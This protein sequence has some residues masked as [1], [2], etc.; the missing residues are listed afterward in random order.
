MKLFERSYSTLWCSVSDILFFVTPPPAFTGICGNAIHYNCD[1]VCGS[2]EACMCNKGWNEAFGEKLSNFRL[3]SFR[4][5]VLCHPTPLR[6]QAFV[7]MQYIRVA[8]GS[9]GQEKLAC[10]IRVETKN[11]E[12]SYPTLCC[13]ASDILSFVTPPP[14]VHRHLYQCNT[15]GLRWGLWVKRSLHVQ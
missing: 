12:R 8:M 6:S 4:Y 14:C 5:F 1:G 7:S 13:S 10:A 3:L 11:L 2:R 9:V 15:L